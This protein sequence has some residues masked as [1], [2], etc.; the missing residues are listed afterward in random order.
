LRGLE[1]DWIVVRRPYARVPPRVD[2]TLTDH[3]RSLC[4]LVAGICGWAEAN[5]GH[6]EKARTANDKAGATDKVIIVSE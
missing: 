6:V 5:I 3:R 4:E 2:Y 1:R